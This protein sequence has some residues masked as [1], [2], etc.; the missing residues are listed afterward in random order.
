MTASPP[1]TTTV[2]WTPLITGV[3]GSQAY[4]LAGPDS[5]TDLLS[6]SAAPTTEFHGLNPPWAKR[7]TRVSHSPDITVHEV[8][9]FISL[10]LSANPTVNELLWLPSD[11]YRVM[12]TLGMELL[13]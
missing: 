10:C 6:V 3:V 7:A 12:H 5:D 11:C 9:K 13:G 8:G 4:G 2:P 1:D